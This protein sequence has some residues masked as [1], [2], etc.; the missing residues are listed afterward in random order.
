MAEQRLTREVT[1]AIRAS[2]E[3][4]EDWDAAVRDLW[5]ATDFCAMSIDEL[6]ERVER[7]EG[8]VGGGAS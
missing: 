1:K 6:F 3:G 7:L 4:C 5:C 2:T 8:T